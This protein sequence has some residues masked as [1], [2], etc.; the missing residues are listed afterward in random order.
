M[1]KRKRRYFEETFK[2]QLVQRFLNGESKAT[3]IKEYE[4]S[5]KVF[6]EWIKRYESPIVEQE[7]LLE[8]LNELD[9]EVNR[10]RQENDKLHQQ[11]EAYK[12]LIVTSIERDKK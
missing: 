9:E 12:I 1:D 3:I 8:K 6:N 2:I 7:K 5:Q 11:N 4:L 10:L